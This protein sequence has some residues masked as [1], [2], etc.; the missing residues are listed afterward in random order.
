[1]NLQDRE[2]EGADWINLFQVRDEWRDVNTVM[3]SQVT[4]KIKEISLVYEEK[5]AYQQSLLSI[6]LVTAT[7]SKYSLTFS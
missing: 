5:S 7:S 2:C 1:V 4:K 6:E 3:N